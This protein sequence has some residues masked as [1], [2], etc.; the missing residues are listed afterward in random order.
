LVAAGGIPSWTT[1]LREKKIPR[2]QRK[3]IEQLK[4]TPEEKLAHRKI[5]K[6]KYNFQEEKST[7]KIIK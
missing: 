7:H 4:N 5:I 1:F 3:T 6:W 2:S